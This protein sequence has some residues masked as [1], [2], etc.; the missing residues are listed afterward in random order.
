MGVTLSTP[1]PSSLPPTT[2]VV[3]YDETNHGSTNM[4][5]GKESGDDLDL[6]EA[7]TKLLLVDRIRALTTLR[8]KGY[9]K[10][11]NQT[12]RGEEKALL[13]SKIQKYD[14]KLDT[15]RDQEDRLYKDSTMYRDALHQIQ[16]SL[17]STMTIFAI[18][19]GLLIVAVSPALL[20]AASSNNN[21]ACLAQHQSDAGPRCQAYQYY[22]YYYLLVL[23]VLGVVL[24]IVILLQIR[25][26]HVLMDDVKH[27]VR[28]N[29]R[30][31]ACSETNAASELL[32]VTTAIPST[33]T[34]IRNSWMRQKR[35][36]LG[37][38]VIFLTAWLVSLVLLIVVLR[39]NVG[40][41]L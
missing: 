1:S 3:M 21:D 19:Q 24:S 12:T 18:V 32:L 14:A 17:N 23:T 31:S 25:E 41:N 7:P 20:L 9:Q 2:I 39:P 38:P 33:S 37:V 27:C 5:A 26:H 4:N 22:Y 36:D 35:L 11:V 10:L 29:H 13:Q 28:E 15:L 8:D 34:T 30:R 40:T 16:V 6:E